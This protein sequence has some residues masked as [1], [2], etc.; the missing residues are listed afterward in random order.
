MCAYL[1]I[2]MARRPP[3]PGASHTRNRRP[4]TGIA[5]PSLATSSQEVLAV[6]ASLY[7]QLARLALI[8]V[9]QDERGRVVLERID[10]G[11]DVFGQ[12]RHG[13]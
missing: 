12:A 7:D 10:K 5:R 2:L 4:C 13:A 11:G 8:Q 1:F 9:D 3:D 6:G